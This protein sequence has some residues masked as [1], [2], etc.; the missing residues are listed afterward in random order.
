[1]KRGNPDEP[2]IDL[3]LQ[4]FMKWAKDNGCQLAEG[5]TVASS[6]SG[7]PSSCLLQKYFCSVLSCSKATVT[8]TEDLRLFLISRAQLLEFRKILSSPQRRLVKCP[9]GNMSKIYY[10]KTSQ[11]NLCCMHFSSE[12][13][14]KGWRSLAPVKLFG[15][16]LKNFGLLT[17]KFYPAWDIWKNFLSPG[18]TTSLPCKSHLTR[19]QIQWVAVCA[20]FVAPRWNKPYLFY[21]HT[22]KI[23][24]V[25]L[26]EGYQN[27]ILRH[28]P[29]MYFHGARAFLVLR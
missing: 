23:C 12:A 19:F 2:D 9:L 24:F 14:R 18:T 15:Q 13:W 7:Q 21:M 5:V 3:A 17:L 26:L 25:G 20:F 29:N 22:R 16:K 11:K 28:F 6:R 10:P 4:D 8:A 27:W 1:M